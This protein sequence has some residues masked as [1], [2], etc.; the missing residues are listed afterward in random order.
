[1]AVIAWDGSESGDMDVDANWAGGVK[2]AGG[3]TA[4]IGTAGTQPSSGILA[5][6]C[7]ITAGADSVVVTGGTF[8][9]AVSLTRG[10]V[11]G[12]TFNSTIATSYGG[13]YPEIRG[14]AF[15][16][17]ASLYAVFL[18]GGTFNGNVTITGYVALIASVALLV[19][20][21]DFA[22]GG[23]ANTIDVST[24]AMSFNKR[25]SL[26]NGTTWLYPPR[27]LAG[28]LQSIETG[29]AL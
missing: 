9:G 12:G 11:T 1:M 16:G 23:S 8:N 5:V 29:I 18:R 7:T 25:L 15:N 17:A 14:G 10:Y 3:N 28:Q 21:G 2:P 24:F 22:L 26:D 4:S 19:F 27:T 13:G 6:A 20:N